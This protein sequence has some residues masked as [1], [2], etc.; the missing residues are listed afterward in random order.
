MPFSPVVP[1][2]LPFWAF[3]REQSRL[4]AKL[5]HKMADR[6]APAPPTAQPSMNTLLNEVATGVDEW[7][8]T[9]SLDD[10][11]PPMAR[12]RPTALGPPPTQGN[13]Y[14]SDGEPLLPAAV[15]H[16]LAEMKKAVERAKRKLEKS[17]AREATL[18]A[19]LQ[20][21]KAKLSKGREEQMRIAEEAQQAVAKAKAQIAAAAA[22]AAAATQRKKEKQRRR[23]F[24]DD[25]GGDEEDP[26]DSL[27]PEAMRDSL[28][29]F[30]PER[31]G[32][33]AAVLGFFASRLRRLLSAVRSRI[34][35]VWLR[36]DVEYI[37]VRFGSSV[38]VY[39]AY[40]EML[41]NLAL[42][43]AAVW[44]TVQVMSIVQH[45]DG[46][47]PNV[48][49]RMEPPMSY[50]PP[51]QLLFASYGGQPFGEWQ[52]LSLA[53]AVTSVAYVAWYVLFTTRRVVSERHRKHYL[54]IFTKQ[55]K[56]N[57]ARQVLTS[58]D[59]SISDEASL[60]E[61]QMAALNSLRMLKAENDFRNRI[62]ERTRADARRLF[63]RRLLMLTLHA[64]LQGSVWAA[65]I[66]AQVNSTV[67]DEAAL[68]A[69]NSTFISSI[70]SVVIYTLLIELMPALCPFLVRAC[71]WDNPKVGRIHLL[72]GFYL[73]R[74]I[75]LVFLGASELG[76]LIDWAEG[77]DGP[78]WS[79]GR[80]PSRDQYGCGQDQ[81]AAK[82]LQQAIIGF[83]L[84]KLAEFS[85]ALA[86]W[87]FAKLRG[88]SWTR[89]A[90]LVEKKFIRNVYFQ[91]LL[92][93]SIPYFPLMAFVA[94]LLLFLEFKLDK[95][96]LLKLCNKTTS[97]FQG[98][99]S[100]LLPFHTITMYLFVAAWVFAFVD[101]YYA[102]DNCGPFY[103]DLTGWANLTVST[104]LSLQVGASGSL[105][106]SIVFDYVISNAYLVWL[107]AFSL[108]YGLI[109]RGHRIGVLQEYVEEQALSE[110]AQRQVLQAKAQRLERQVDKLKLQIEQAG[111]DGL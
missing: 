102:V 5:P 107:L 49:D 69:L 84:P 27:M 73:G 36:F 60:K 104:Y 76:M 8:G 52:R 56:L 57:F 53:Y 74:I 29:D 17:R 19:E 1:V 65:I 6:V 103:D 4:T 89:N 75:G 110:S 11:A 62:K 18:T 50:L 90:F 48:P 81:L 91:G 38:S 59:V 94:P 109:D 79:I 108:L 68:N 41:C 55:D 66:L 35:R 31:R 47:A 87:G 72:G 98:D 101:Q 34:N 92:W 39:F 85:A 45:A 93:I 22:D 30:D 64:L 100:Q 40:S 3:H 99:L 63:F 46:A 24:L 86:K 14:E 28:D 10:T 51:K 32:V 54:E 67:L 82:F 21:A 25:A 70:F 23:L 33:C 95:L 97:P 80:K 37:E 58:W 106:L 16:T 42:G 78:R 7:D 77:T 105:V 15:E 96:F 2:E 111:G 13:G 61:Q 71:K 26:E 9:S 20:Q 44:M 83:A 43:N 12:I 88:K